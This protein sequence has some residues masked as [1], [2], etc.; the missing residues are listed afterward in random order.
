[1]YVNLINRYILFQLLYIMF[2]L[3]NTVIEFDFNTNEHSQ[4]TKE[5]SG[6]YTCIR[7]QERNKST[8]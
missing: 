3:I 7:L 2:Y 4:Y 8:H 6:L 1:M 5:W